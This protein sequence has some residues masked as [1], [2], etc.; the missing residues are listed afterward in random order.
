MQH[1]ILVP[2]EGYRGINPIIFG[3]DECARNLFSPTTRKFWLIHYV[4]S[5]H[6]VFLIRGKEYRIGPGD[7][8]VTPPCVEIRYHEDDDDPWGYMWIGFSCDGELPL[9]LDD[10]IY[11]P[12]AIR[13]FND[14]KKCEHMST[15]LAA[16]LNARIWDLFALL[17]QNESIDKGNIDKALDYIHSEYM[18]DLNVEQIAERLNLDRSYFSS[19]FKK[20]V[21]IPPK[22][23]LVNYRMKIAASLLVDHERSVS[24][25]AYSVGYTDTFNFSKMFKK[26]YGMSPTEYARIKKR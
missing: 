23:Y 8:F 11:Y 21:G 5:G 13:I 19:L 1:D 15:G 17:I 6:G 3:W 18:N 16:Y 7:L 12:E 22:Q 2:S 25:A 20:K 9:K 26:H 4:V 14:M 24:A 10:V